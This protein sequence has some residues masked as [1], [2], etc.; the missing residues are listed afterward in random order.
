MFL[1]VFSDAP[2][3][4]TERSN[5]LNGP[6]GER[7]AKKVLI[8]GLDCARLIWFSINEAPPP[9]LRRL[10]EDGIYGSSS[11]HSTHHDSGWTSMS[12]ARIQAPWVSTESKPAGYSYDKMIFANSVYVKEDTLW[13]ILSAREEVVAMA[14]PNV[15]AQTRQRVHDH[16]FLTPD[17]N[18]RYTYPDS[19]NRDRVVVGEYMLDVDNSGPKKRTNC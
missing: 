15:S 8:I 4:R 5:A 11:R 12:P 2:A 18:S 19:L 3:I 13:N 10:M 7:M 1:P 17:T 6:L 9:S 14:S 16:L